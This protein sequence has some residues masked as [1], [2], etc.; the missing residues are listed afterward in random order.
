MDELQYET[1]IDHSNLL[2]GIIHQGSQLIPAFDRF[3]FDV[4]LLIYKYK[5]SYQALPTLL[6]SELILLALCEHPLLEKIRLRTKGSSSETYLAMKLITD[7]LLEQLR[8]SK[9]LQQLKEG[10]NLLDAFSITE[11]D[12][13]KSL[14]AKS[15]LDLSDLLMTLESINQWLKDSPVGVPNVDAPNVGDSNV[16]ASAP[17]DPIGE[18]LNLAASYDDVKQDAKEKLEKALDTLNAEATDFKESL[19][20]SFETRFAAIIKSYTLTN[21]QGKSPFTSIESPLESGESTDEERLVSGKPNV[22]QTPSRLEISYDLQSTMTEIIDTLHLD[23][24]I[25]TTT[26]VL[27]QF[28]HQM[29][30][31]G[32]MKTERNTLTF[33]EVLG[34]YKRAQNPQFVE[35]V[36][37]VGKKKANLRAITRKKKK[38]KIIPKDRVIYSDQLD[39]LIDDELIN[40]SMAIEAFE[41][42]FYTRYLNDALLTLELVGEDEK[43]KGPIILCYDGSGSMKGEKIEETKALILSVIE[44]AKFQKRPIVLIQF[45][46]A[47]EPMF[48]KQ[49][50]PQMFATTDLLEILDTYICG[51]TDF[52]K[53][54][55]EAL[56]HIRSAAYKKS[57]IL[58]I[59]DG[60]CQIDSKFKQTFMALKK[61]MHFK[62]YTVI[63]HSHT[64]NDYGDIGEISD[65][66]LDIKADNLNHWNEAIDSQIYQII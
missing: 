53:P 6:P 48:I 37:K 60:Q 14:Y 54:L 19:K 28:A 62:L 5:I 61:E 31:L 65:K 1:L 21:N 15:A 39:Y 46:S 23:D 52:K 33:D 59:T 12:S 51:G 25:K 3:L 7:L 2:K 40:V 38:Q 11:R 32:L 29:D 17:T 4:F 45:A 20:E 44:L 42:D 27:D 9:M 43:H 64:Y 18:A 55:Q 36:N 50:N 13:L 63:I 26:H 56:V 34:L 16:G 66:I 10:S 35:F 47:S 30:T 24:V 41:N 22:S 58:F 8:G 57:D 49:I